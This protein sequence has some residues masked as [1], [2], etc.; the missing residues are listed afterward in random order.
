MI[1]TAESC[2]GGMIA[3]KVTDIP[4]TSGMFLGGVCTYTEEI[5][6][7]VLGVSEN[8]LK[9][10][11]VYSAQTASEMSKGAMKL[12]GADIAIGVTGI[13]G[14]DGGTDEKPVGTVF[15]SV[16]NKEKEIVRNL[17]L[18]DSYENLTRDKIRLLTT[19]KA[20]EMTMELC[21][22]QKAEG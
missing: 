16:R 14:P 2:T 11:T 17:R 12:F 13:A 19:G 4:G 15:V 22:N 9:K 7:R 5:K 6:M 18:Y 8:T 20:L 10:F 1:S 3:E 21:E